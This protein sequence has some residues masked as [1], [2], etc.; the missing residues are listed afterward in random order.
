M[1]LFTKKTT[2]IAQRCAKLVFMYRL[3]CKIYIDCLACA[4]CTTSFE[5]C[6]NQYIPLDALK[7]LMY[8]WLCVKNIFNLS[9]FIPQIDFQEI[10]YDSEYSKWLLYNGI[11]I[12]VLTVVCMMSYLDTIMLLN[13][14]DDS[15]QNYNYPNKYEV[16]K[17]FN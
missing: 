6:K 13:S 2:F 7:S 16:F 12:V 10:F 14:F 8:S 5:T 4:I 15:I 17:C 9:I 1:S 11:L 3:F